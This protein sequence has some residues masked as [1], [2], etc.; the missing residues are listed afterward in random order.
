MIRRV[1][2]KEKE[3]ENRLFHFSSFSFPISHSSL[4]YVATERR[5]AGNIGLLE[6]RIL[7]RLLASVALWINR[8]LIFWRLMCDRGLSEA[9][10]ISIFYIIN[11]YFLIT[12]L[13]TRSCLLHLVYFLSLQRI[14]ETGRRLASE[15]WFIS[16]IFILFSI[17]SPSLRS[18]SR[19]TFYLLFTHSLSVFVNEWKVKRK[20]IEKKVQRERA[21]LSVSERR[22]WEKWRCVS[23]AFVTENWKWEYGRR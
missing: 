14:N 1:R 15:G 10:I 13:L 20:T 4:C 17:L 3:K 8:V 21:K 22:V 12:N 23:E 9:E 18:F 7:S 11:K 19:W 5:R 2:V 16:R 6:N